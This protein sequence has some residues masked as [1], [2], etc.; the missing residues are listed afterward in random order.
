[1]QI[2]VMKIPV[3]ACRDF[4]NAKRKEKEVLSKTDKSNMIF[5][6]HAHYE[7]SRFDK[8]R[9]QLL[10]SMDGHGITAIVN[11]GSTVY[12]TN[13]SIA[14]AKTYDFMYASV[15]IHPSEIRDI[16]E[17]DMEWLYEQTKEPRVVAVGE[18]GLD[19]YWEKEEA[20][21]KQQRYWFE[22]QLLL[23]KESGL[24]VIIHSRDAAQDTL[25]LMKQAHEMHIPGVIH[26][27]SY[28]AQIAQEYVRMGYYIGIGGV[29]TFKNA[30]KLKEAVASIPL[31]QIVLE[32]DC[33]YMAPEPYRGKRNS[34]LY[35]P[36]VVKQVAQLKGVSE[37]E[38]VQATNRNARRLYRIDECA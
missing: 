3:T 36:Y 25:E 26:C 35:L 23:A 10:A 9:E 11:V 17:G 32:T 28:S 2:D 30:K 4:H 14:L 8:D 38:V 15:G 27:F 12:T 16:E 6:T 19:Y 1:M 37:Q 20:V 29:V 22:K 31:E 21:Q 34:S 18:I 33:P 5:D 24:P 7:D 13:K